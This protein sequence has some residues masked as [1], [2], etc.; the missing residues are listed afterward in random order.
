[1]TLSDLVARHARTGPD[2]VAFSDSRVARTYGE[3]DGRVTRLANALTAY[4]VGH[5]ERVAVLGLNSVELVESYLAVLRRRRD[6]RAGELPAGRRR[7]R[8]TCCPTP[9]RWP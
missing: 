2:R 9:A 5:G 7:D 8:P 6:L 3:I 4:G 1:M